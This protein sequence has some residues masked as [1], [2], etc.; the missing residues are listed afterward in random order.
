M[1]TKAQKI[2]SLQ[3]ENVKRLKAV[4]INA[5]G[6]IVVVGGKNAQGKSSV[7]DAIA[8]AIGGKNE[9]PA[10]PVR[11]GADKAQIIVKTEDFIIRRTFTAAGGTSLIVENNEGAR[12]SSPQE[13]LGKL[14]GKVCFDPLAFTRLDEKKQLAQLRELVGLDFAAL[15]ADR[16]RIYDERTLVNRDVSTAEANIQAMPFHADAPKE[17]L[18]REVAEAEL[19]QA[20]KDNA[21]LSEIRANVRVAEDRLETARHEGQRTLGEINDIERE[22]AELQERLAA[23]KE[24]LSLVEEEVKTRKA[25]V[26]EAKKVSSL[27]RLIDTSALRAKLAEID[28]L[29]QKRRDNAARD[30]A[31]KKLEAAKKHSKELTA[32]IE[33]IDANKAKQLEAAK[34][35]VEGMSFD[36]SGILYKGIPFVQASAAEQLRVS[37]AMAC[38]LNPTL[39]VMIVRDGSLLDDDSL[40]LLFALA[41]EYDVQVWI[42]RVGTDENTSVVIEDGAVAN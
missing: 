38:A 35:P 34:F 18:S 28:A 31:A 4:E 40:K 19:S 26:E 12:Y 2:I 1:A 5:N 29:N 20:E 33:A 39:R 24:K 9:V 8:M 13:L 37:V 42:E 25:A 21:R 15:D 11:E 7:L 36:E 17:A 6:E 23:R 14:T 27:E 32:K 41:K 30:E 16:K 10:K 3:A 22:I